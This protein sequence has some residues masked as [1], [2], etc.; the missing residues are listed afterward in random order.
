MNCAPAPPPQDPNDLGGGL[1]QE[2]AWG[3]VGGLVG[4]A[5]LAGIVIFLVMRNPQQG[6]AV[7]PLGGF[8]GGGGGG[9]GGF[10]GGGGWPAPAP[11]ENPDNG[12]M[13][14]G[15]VPTSEDVGSSRYNTEVGQTY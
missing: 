2:G 14:N 13:D 12:G 10:G 1:S 7:F 8:G 3:I 15:R 4:A 6:A 11:G 9:G 5:V